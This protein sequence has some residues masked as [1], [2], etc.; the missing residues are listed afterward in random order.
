MINSID[1]LGDGKLS[2]FTG[3]LE[4]YLQPEI[5]VDTLDDLQQL[6]IKDQFNN[7]VKVDTTISTIKGVAFAGTFADLETQIRALAL[8][9]NGLFNGGA[10]GGGG[11]GDASA[12]NQ[13]TQITELQ[14]IAAAV[15]MPSQLAGRTSV[16]IVADTTAPSLEYTVTPGKT[17]YVSDILL[18]IENS[19][20][21]NSGRLELYDSLVSP[22]VEPLIV[23]FNIPES[24]ASE[25]SIS[26]ISHTFKE[27]VLFSSGV[28][29]EE[30]AGTLTMTG[31]INGYE[32]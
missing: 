16:K 28:W 2:A 27:P 25:T 26:I 21:N 31:I 13:L 3:A 6:I 10:G 7:Y 32:E 20:Q 29:F 5:I 11:G 8:E 18:T 9:S 12:A 24:T 1:I 30:A 22:T 23:P 14:K 15:F 19:D 17:F 4:T